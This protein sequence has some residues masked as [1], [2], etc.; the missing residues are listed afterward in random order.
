[1]K[2]ALVFGGSGQAG[3][4]LVEQL[5]ADGYHVTSSMHESTPK[6]LS[7][8]STLDYKPFFLSV[9][10]YTSSEI[11]K[12]IKETKPDVI[13]NLIGRMYAPNSWNE[14]E[15]YFRI[16]GGIVLE[17][18]ESIEK[19]SPDTRFVN[20]GSA[21]MYGIWQNRTMSIFTERRPRNPY[22]L[23]KSMAFDAVRMYREEKGLQ[24]ST[25]V[26]F[27]MESPRRSEFFF[28][29]K[30]AK[31]VVKLARKEKKQITFGPLSAVR[32][33]G[34]APDYM[35][36]MRM[37]AN[38][39]VTKDFVIATGESHSCRSFVEEALDVIGRKND[40]KQC[41]IENAGV[42]QTQM[43]ASIIHTEEGLAWTPKYR[44]KDVVR[45]LVQAELGKKVA[46]A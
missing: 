30:V 42:E 28:A 39:P 13:F 36:A 32:D 45:M 8:V 21:E 35:E 37:M 4:Y 16:N 12:I 43:Y 6:N 40:F 23:A 24:C 14:A 19:F 20:A 25:A 17:I 10:E 46:T 3:S 5:L 15:S 26:F 7:A 33:W 18:L 1:M 44:F 9:C 22:G 31:E 34:W 27:N 2:R 38:R 11:W 41:V 29:Q